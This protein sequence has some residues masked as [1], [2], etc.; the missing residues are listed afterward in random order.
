MGIG[1]VGQNAIFGVANIERKK[2]DPLFEIT[3]NLGNKQVIY[4]GRLYPFGVDTLLTVKGVVLSKGSI[5]THE[6]AEKLLQKVEELD[7]VTF[8]VVSFS[9][10]RKLP[11]T[12]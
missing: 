6:A 5:K 1:D 8:P 9:Q 10:I 4:I 11:K 12:K 7:E 2:Y 3:V